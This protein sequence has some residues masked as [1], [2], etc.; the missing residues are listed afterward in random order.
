MQPV[1]AQRLRTATEVAT[2]LV[3][4]SVAVLAIMLPISF[5]SL[6][7]FRHL[8]LL[9]F[10][11][12]RAM[13]GG[14]FA[15]VIT[16]A[17]TFAVGSVRTA[18]W[19]ALAA[20]GGILLNHLALIP[21][22]DDGHID[23]LSLPTLN[24]ID[25]LLAGMAFGALAVAVW[26]RPLLRGVYLFAAVGATIIGDLTQT[27]VDEGTDS[28]DGLLA[29]AL[30]LW[31]IAATVLA[32]AYFAIT[33]APPPRFSP[34]SAIPLAPVFAALIAY[35]TILYTSLSLAAHA[36]SLGRLILVAT[37][38]VAATTAAAFVLPGR[39]GLLVPLLAG[40]AVVGSLVITLPR[41]GWVDL[42][43]LGA[44][45]VGLLLGLRAPRVLLAAGCVIALGL[46]TLAVDVFDPPA[47]LVAALG[48]LLLGGIGGFCVGAA[49]PENP[50][51]VVVG[52][53]I[54][55][56]PS[57]GVALSDT[58]FGHLAYSPSWYRT[59]V[60]DRGATPATAGIAIAIAC[61]LAIALVLRL[62]PPVDPPAAD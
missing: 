49:V 62:R 24:F 6:I 60:V 4:T 52:L 28:F 1:A 11:I 10:N 44:V 2:V 42:A 38:V 5:A 23:G 54:L 26:G 33:E 21:I 41:S 45:G 8:D 56:V 9:V 29:G 48:C 18:R 3:A 61:A 40:F 57:A 43:T 13:T 58:E 34:D 37:A 7:A 20:L 17:V 16:A 53:G 35:P 46:Y 31:F 39:D 15:A 51:S 32:L 50:S 14:A 47:T 30:P 12:P 19:T 27:P 55:F 22:N 36:A 25:A 59:T